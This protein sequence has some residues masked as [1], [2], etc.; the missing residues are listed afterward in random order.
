MR[1]LH[2][3][4]CKK[5]NLERRIKKLQHRNRDEGEGAYSEAH[6]TSATRTHP[7][8][9]TFIHIQKLTF[10]VSTI[11]PAIR[12]LTEAKACIHHIVKFTA[13]QLQN[14]PNSHE[15]YN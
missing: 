6:M 4:N 3:L 1:I 15:Y 11:Q 10:I 13:I 8:P 2:S 12:T 5:V 7:H 9:Q 14:Q